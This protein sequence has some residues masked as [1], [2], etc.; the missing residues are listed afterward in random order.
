LI[1][2]H[3]HLF[4]DSIKNNIS[5]VISNAKK[6]N[7][8]GILS[9]NT[10]KEDF[11]SHYKLIEKYKSIFISYGEHPENINNHNIIS[12]KEIISLCSLE[13]IIGIGETGI[14]LFYSK[15]NFGAQLK[16]FENHI[17][18]SIK[19]NIP[20]IIHQ[21]NSETEI[22]DILSNFKNDNLK[23]VMHCF[24]GSK[25]MR[26]FCIESNYYISLTGII[27]FKNANELRNTIK[28]I[29]L[30]LILIETDSPF[31]TPE[32]FRGVKPNQPSYVYYICEYLASFFN[33]K[34][35]EFEIITDNNFYS[36][37]NKAI[38]YKEI[39][40]EN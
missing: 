34:L 22:I 36:L 2:S 11:D 12:A 29:P 24:T 18:A 23:L 8:T 21:R 10:K 20:L 32:P 15:D 25:K 35:K 33:L 14:D 28:D 1:D 3:C 6:N 13:K 5:E 17:E 27:T 9:I 37:F 4:F 38:R 39:S 26:D 19:T 30:N 7:V 16:S 40:Y 31:L